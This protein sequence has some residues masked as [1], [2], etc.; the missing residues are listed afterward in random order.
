MKLLVEFFRDH[1]GG[2]ALSVESMAAVDDPDV[3]VPSIRNLQYHNTKAKHLVKAA[4][5]IKSQFRGQVPEDEHSLKQITGIGPVLADLL[6]FVNTK[7]RH[8][9]AQQELQQPCQK[10]AGEE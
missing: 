3:M 4:Q 1:N 8:H 2:G 6:A 5:E 7:E 10:E 9:Q